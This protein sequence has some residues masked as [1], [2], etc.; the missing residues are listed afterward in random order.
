MNNKNTRKNKMNFSVVWPTTPYFTI[1]D[2]I[3]LNPKF[4]EITLRVRLT[5]A[6]DEEDRFAEIG[7]VPGAKGR[8]QKIFAPTPVTKDVL[9]KAEEAGISL[10]DKARDKFIGVV[11]VTNITN[12]PVP[13]SDS[14]PV[15]I[16]APQKAMTA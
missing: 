16:G 1:K 14:M 7:F 5:N 11:S 6:I 8:P 10:V 4:V 15:H 3:K 2:L 13:V 12:V 9:D